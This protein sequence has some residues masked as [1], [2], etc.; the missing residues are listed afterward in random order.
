MSSNLKV[1]KSNMHKFPIVVFFK[2]IEKDNNE[3]NYWY[4]ESKK[5]FGSENLA[6]NLIEHDL[7]DIDLIQ[8]LDAG[9]LSS[10]LEEIKNQNNCQIT[11]LDVVL[12]SNLSDVDL[13]LEYSEN[14]V[15]RF[16]PDAFEE[17]IGI[18]NGFNVRSKRVSLWDSF[19]KSTFFKDSFYVRVR[20]K[21]D[22][23]ARNSL[24]L[25]DRLSHAFSKNR[26]V[27][28]QIPFFLMTTLFSGVAC[29]GV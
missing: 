7:S 1:S 6:S 18:A 12:D 22:F 23:L 10:L 20:V 3:S 19:F 27:T 4:V 28:S 25:D 9:F 24:M 15:H 13:L 11:F 2:G 29:S 21:T 17:V 16:L 26:Y 5:M 14:S 8:K